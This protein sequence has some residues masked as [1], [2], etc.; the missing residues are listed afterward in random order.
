[1]TE[2]VGTTVASP[3]D[4]YAASYARLVGAVSLAAGNQSEAED[5]VQEAFVRLLPRW[6]TVGN[7]D[8]P[9]A[10]VRQVA[11][12]VLSNRRRKVR[13]GI[14]AVA[15]SRPREP[16]GAVADDRVDVAQALASLPLN[17]RQVVV[18]H[19][20]L[21]LDVAS[22]AAELGVP[23]GTVKSRLSRARQ[24]LAPLLREDVTDHA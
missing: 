23:V 11:F 24:T 20:L 16:G 21:D 18:L 22:V 19:H 6:A 12:R 7:Y 4:L 1:V 8:D 10:W 5:V 9:E 17:Q 3:A 13:N 15:R 14:R 2:S